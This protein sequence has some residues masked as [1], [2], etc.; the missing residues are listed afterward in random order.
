MAPLLEATAYQL[1][2]STPL[3]A[4]YEGRLDSEWLIGSVANGGYSLAIV[5]VCAHDFLANQLK[6]THKDPFHVASTYL[7]ATDAKEKWQV[8]VE[9]TKR[10]KGFTNLNANL[11]QKVRLVSERE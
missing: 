3:R 8:E 2:S 6:S 11:V 9:V 1:V 5:N 10:G 4:T 7:N